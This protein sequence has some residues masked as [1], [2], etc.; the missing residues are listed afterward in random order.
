[1]KSALSTGVTSENE[2]RLSELLSCNEQCASFTPDTIH[3]TIQPSGQPNMYYNKRLHPRQYVVES[4]RD[5]CMLHELE[6]QSKISRAFGSL[7]TLNQ[8][9]FRCCSAAGT[10]SGLQTPRRRLSSTDSDRTMAQLSDVRRRDYKPRPLS[11][12]GTATGCDWSISVAERMRNN[13]TGTSTNTSRT[14]TSTS[15]TTRSASQPT[16]PFRAP[17]SA[18]ATASPSTS[19]SYQPHHDDADDSAST[20]RLSHSIKPSTLHSKTSTTQSLLKNVHFSRDCVE[21]SMTSHG[22]ATESAF[23]AQRSAS[24][25]YKSPEQ[26]IATLFPDK[27]AKPARGKTVTSQPK[28]TGRPGGVLKSTKSSVARSVASTAATTGR[29]TQLVASPAFGTK[30]RSV[31]RDSRGVIRADSLQELSRDFEQGIKYAH[32]DAC[33]FNS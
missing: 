28:T 22:A 17:A 15:T 23:T 10:P 32:T 13:A 19:H 7:S 4:H 20:S 2:R 12:A 21:H 5:G 25:S 30:T 16:T 6:E 11:I 29:K 14:S 3:N 26:I 8:P 18:F 27:V 33:V 31:S 24:D 1:M 9:P